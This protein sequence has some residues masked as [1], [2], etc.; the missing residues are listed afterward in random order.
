[1]NTFGTIL[2]LTTFG[3]SH[4]QAVGGV[5][6]GYP[7]G[8]K[9]D[10]GEAQESVSMRSPGKTKGSTSRNESDKVEWL[11]GILDGVSLGTPIGFIIRNNDQHSSDYSEMRHVYRP[12][13]ADFTWQEKYGIR[14]WRGGGRASA[15]ETA[16]RVAAGSLAIQALRSKGIEI[17]SYAKQIGNVVL[18]KD[19]N[20]VD[21]RK[22][23]QNDARCPDEKTASRMIES[24]K[25]AQREEDSLGGAV[26][27]IV[28][29]CPIGLGDPVYDKLSAK[30]SYGMMSI[31]AVKA[32][33]IGLGKEFASKKGSEVND[34]FTVENESIHTSSN[35]SGGIQGGISNGED[36]LLRVTFKPIASISRL[37]RTVNDNLEEVDLR[38]KGRHDSCAVPRAVPV[39]QSMAALT[40]LDSLLMNRCSKF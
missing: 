34:E 15:R 35:N 24:M 16:C 20:Q 23:Y 30:L 36:I 7:D 2:R 25:N 31:P 1:M 5:L 4:G 32:F 40:I 21:L 38:I 10:L 8:V 12:S 14:D 28:K 3:E 22:I 13:H 9:L 29:N 27:C 26:E 19:C 17:Y 39:V 37:Q 18:E 6:D 11:S 33:E